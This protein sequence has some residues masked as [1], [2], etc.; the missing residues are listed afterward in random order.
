MNDLDIKNTGKPTNPRRLQIYIIAAGL[1]LAAGIA[2][3][4]AYF[5]Q[6]KTSPPAEQLGE[7]SG[8]TTEAVTPS[9]I[10]NAAPNSQTPNPQPTPSQSPLI[11]STPFRTGG[12]EDKPK[13]KPAPRL[14]SPVAEGP[15]GQAKPDPCIAAKTELTATQEQAQKI[16][17]SETAA[18]KQGY[19]DEQKNFDAQLN[20]LS[21]QKNQAINN[22]LTAIALATA[23][24]N[25]S[26][27]YSSDYAVYQ[28]EQSVALSDY[29]LASAG[30]G[31]QEEDLTKQKSDSKTRYD[32]AL[33]L[34]AAT[35]TSSQAAAQVAYAAKCP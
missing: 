27:K 25:L 12:G 31:T 35:L 29:N 21:I 17:D 2:G 20:Q 15:G 32:E 9:E 7:T 6:D 24:Y 13:P 26:S 23:K 11:H 18:A 22:Y 28:Q 1:V 19:D 8:I 16:Y 34:A 33:A 3:G 4:A 5:G 10:N 14:P 30:L